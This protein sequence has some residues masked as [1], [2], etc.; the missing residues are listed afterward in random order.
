VTLFALG[1]VLPAMSVGAAAIGR[2]AADAAVVK[3]I[4][5][6]GK[7]RLGVAFAPVPTALFV[8]KDAGG[9]PHGVTVDLGEALAQA[10]GVPLDI[11]VAPNTG[12]LTDSLESGRIDVTFMPMDEERRKRVDFGPP[13]FEAESTYLVP[14][15]SAIRS[16]LAADR[17]GV[18]IVGVANTTTIRAAARTAT[19]A[20]VV[21]ATSID[22]AMAMMKAG[23]AQ[24]F[25]M[26]RDALP[27]L[28]QQLPGSHILDGAFQATGIAI[29]VPKGRPGALAFATLFLERAKA[30]GT[31]RRVFDAAGLGT[32]IVAPPHT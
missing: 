29:A 8:I 13:Y 10:L 24:A 7:L 26:G 32:A 18:T 5:P 1:S 31:V 22:D 20:K 14:A 30:D 21:A 16:I 2:A 9:A 11:L 3:E 19:N 12:E 28:Q 6:T 25:A 27:P 17:P 4:A 23:T 15:G